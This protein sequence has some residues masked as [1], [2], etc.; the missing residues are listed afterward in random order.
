MGNAEKDA[1]KLIYPVLNGI[2]LFQETGPNFWLDVRFEIRRDKLHV[3]QYW[4]L[5][6]LDNP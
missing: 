2:S 4:R 3:C 1:T 6:W 5:E